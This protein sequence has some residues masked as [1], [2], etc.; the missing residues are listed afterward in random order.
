VREQVNVIAIGKLKRAPTLLSNYH[1][2]TFSPCCSF[3]SVYHILVNLTK[4]IEPIL[5]KYEKI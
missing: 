3:V 1:P 5:R 4:C 2:A